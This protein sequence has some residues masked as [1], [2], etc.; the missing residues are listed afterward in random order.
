MHIER[1]TY[2]PFSLS[3]SHSSA[4]VSRQQC[5]CVANGDDERTT[6]REIVVQ[7][8]IFSVGLCIR[9]IHSYKPFDRITH[10]LATASFRL[11]YLCGLWSVVT[12]TLDEMFYNFSCELNW[13][14]IEI[15][16]CHSVIHSMGLLSS[17]HVLFLFCFSF[18]SAFANFLLF[19]FSSIADG[20][21]GIVCG[22]NIK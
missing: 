4:F 5:V 1:T 21:G 2:S 15:H 16:Q 12:H 19:L 9:V 20:L 18:G 8:G 3:S 11:Q 7:L 17:L 6:S 14:V 10:T 22:L 13:R